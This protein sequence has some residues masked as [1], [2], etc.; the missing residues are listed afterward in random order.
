MVGSSL[1]KTLIWL[2]ACC[3]ALSSTRQYTHART[4]THKR[5]QVVVPQTGRR[6]ANYIILAREFVVYRSVH[7]THHHRI[8]IHLCQCTTYTYDMRPVYA[9]RLASSHAHPIYSCS[10]KVNGV[11]NSSAIVVYYNTVCVGR[12]WSYYY[13]ACGVMFFF[14]FRDYTS[15]NHKPI[16]SMQCRQFCTHNTQTQRSTMNDDI[17]GHATQ[18]TQQL[19]A[20]RHSITIRSICRLPFWLAGEH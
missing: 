10:Q 7:H 18:T 13:T 12:Q 2:A 20:Q 4:H 15:V 19:H 5:R 16:N 17:Y 6:I 3:N 14:L 8:Y 1:F 11:C 9:A